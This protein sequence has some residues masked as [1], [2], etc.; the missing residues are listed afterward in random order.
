MEASDC[1]PG[2][3]K[4]HVRTDVYIYIYIYIYIYT[5]THKHILWSSYK[6][7]S[8]IRRAF[9]SSFLP[10]DHFTLEKFCGALI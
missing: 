9:H 4:L 2:F 6:P 7:I 1:E 3:S 10:R 8:H 5:H